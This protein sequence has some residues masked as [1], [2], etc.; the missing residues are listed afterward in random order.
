MNQKEFC[1]NILP[2][3]DRLYRYAQSIVKR[4]S[5]ARD[6][7]QDTMIA[8][9]EKIDK[10]EEVRNIEAWCMVVVRNS[11]LKKLRSDK[12]LMVDLNDYVRMKSQRPDPYR[13]LENKDGL[14]LVGRIIEALPQMQ[15]EV[16]VLRDIENYS[17]KE[18]GVI[19][20]IEINHVKVL[21]HRARLAVRS[22]MKKIYDHGVTQAQ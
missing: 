12:V 2:L 11:A 22:E 7:V 1:E 15:R 18:I 20:N 16:I 9:W 6:I 21:I 10:I 4:E 5:I 17:Y 13:Q 14:E 8:A 3:K 19:M